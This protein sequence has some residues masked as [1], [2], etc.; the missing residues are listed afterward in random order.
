LTIGSSA[1]KIDYLMLLGGAFNLPTAGAVKSLY[2]APTAALTAASNVLLTTEYA[3]IAPTKYGAQ[4]LLL[5]ADQIGL[6]YTAADT[7]ETIALTESGLT[8]A[9]TPVAAGD[10]NPG[11]GSSEAILPL[12][13]CDPPVCTDSVFRKECSNGP[14]TKGI[15]L[16]NLSMRVSR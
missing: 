6:V 14:L 12:R 4:S 5:T 7:I 10:S 2:V 11:E 3:L 13:Y 8:V 9:G 15:Q 1:D 16:L